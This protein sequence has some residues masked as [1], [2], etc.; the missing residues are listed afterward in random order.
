[1]VFRK[2]ESR[3]ALNSFYGVVIKNILVFP[4]FP[5][6]AIFINLNNPDEKVLLV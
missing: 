5:D 6:M 4:F 3:I 1:M 2:N